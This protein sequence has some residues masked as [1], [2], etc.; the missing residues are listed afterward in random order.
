MSTTRFTIKR[1]A[2]ALA[3]GLALFVAGCGNAAQRQAYERA[4]QKEQQLTA[5][6]APALIAEYKRVI[7]LQ[8]GSAWARKAQARIEA[9][10]ARLQAAE[11]H[12]S[13]FQEHGVD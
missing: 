1:T 4:A 5:E 13:V 3:I 2:A 6:N 12:K 7:A 9:V 11:L 8:P 10:E